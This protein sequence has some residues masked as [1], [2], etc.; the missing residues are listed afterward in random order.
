MVKIIHYMIFTLVL[1]RSTKFCN[2]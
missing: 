2:T 1:L